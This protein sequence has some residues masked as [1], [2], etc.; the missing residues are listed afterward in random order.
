M[1]ATRETLV[2][3][4]LALKAT[5][6]RINRD[7]LR[8]VHAIPFGRVTTVEAISR[9][10]DVPSHHVAF[11]LAR[12][13]DTEREASPW[14]RVVAHRGA[15]GRP[16]YDAHGRSQVRRLADEGVEVGYRGR[17]GDFSIRYIEP[18]FER[19]D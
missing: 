14:Y 8:V 9:F 3:N 19:A 16:L 17:I 12:R 10:L 5:Y 4:A 13:Y 6:T 15:V 2:G 7:I 18:A 1:S 11:L